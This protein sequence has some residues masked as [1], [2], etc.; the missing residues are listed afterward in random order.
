M[1]FCDI[2]QHINFCFVLFFS[3]RIALAYPG[4]FVLLCK[5]HR[6]RF[7]LHTNG[8]S[9]HFLVS[10]SIISKFLFCRR[11]A[12]ASSVWVSELFRRLSIGST[13]RWFYNCHTEKLPS[14]VCRC[15]HPGTWR[16]VIIRPRSFL[17]YCPVTATAWLLSPFLSLFLTYRSSKEVKPLNDRRGESG[18][19]SLV[20]DFRGHAFN[21]SP[22]NIWP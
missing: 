9:F 4:L 19:Q 13:P 10:S 3:L 8:R 16:N 15:L 7:L 2:L 14:F 11:L 22:F 17:N 21:L 5:F 18:H 6:Y 12:H 20:P 1:K